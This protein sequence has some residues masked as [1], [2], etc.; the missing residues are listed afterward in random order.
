MDKFPRI[1]TKDE[2]GV[3]MVLVAI[4]LLALLGMAGL[5]IDV[6]QL[7]VAK[8]QLTR[9]ADAAALAGVQSLPDVNRAV[10]DALNYVAI[11]EPGATATA[12][13]VGSQQLKVTAS[14]TVPTTFMRVFG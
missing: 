1:R 9:A 11:N 8:A 12:Q 7:V 5:A 10:A 6:G 14:K 4:A 13:Q 3:T 2:Q